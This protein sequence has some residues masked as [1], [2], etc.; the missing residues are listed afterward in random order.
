VTGPLSLAD[1]VQGG[2]H[3]L[4]RNVFIEGYQWRSLAVE[5]RHVARGREYRA[6]PHAHAYGTIAIVRHSF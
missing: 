5:Y 2:A 4:L 6:Q 3:R 1:Q